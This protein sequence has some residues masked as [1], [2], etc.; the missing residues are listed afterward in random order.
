[1]SVAFDAHVRILYCHLSHASVVSGTQVT[2]G[3]LIGQVGS[4]GRSTGPHLHLEIQ[5]DGR[6]VD[7]GR[8]LAATP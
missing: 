1:V 2:A 7:P 3:E 4:T 5:V 8:W 6:F